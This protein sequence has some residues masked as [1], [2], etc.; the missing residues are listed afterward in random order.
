MDAPYPDSKSAACPTGYHNCGQGTY[1]L[2]RSVCEPDVK[3]PN[4]Q[5]PQPCPLNWLGSTATISLFGVTDASTLTATSTGFTPEPTQVTNN[6]T[7][8]TVIYGQVG[9]TNMIKKQ[10]PIVELQ[11]DFKQSGDQGPCYT[12]NS[13]QNSYAS[14]FSLSSTTGG[15]TPSYPSKCSESDPRWMPFDINIESSYLQENFKTYTA[16]AN[17]PSTGYNPDYFSTPNNPCDP[18]A[19]TG[20]KQCVGIY[21]YQGSVA[22]PTISECNGDKLCLTANYQ[23]KC[24]FLMASAKASTNTMGLYMRSQIYWSET[25]PY[26]YDQVKQSNGPLQKAI[27]SQLALLIINII[28]NIIV[29]LLALWAFKEILCDRDKSDEDIIAIEKGWGP[30]ISSCSTW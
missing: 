16:C 24:G 21:T 27:S 13:D 22:R 17:I 7:V 10:L 26:K 5:D 23:S 14:S 4:P 30:K 8:P 19:T 29:I 28:M 6:F 11:M 2:T 3:L 25:C 12:F 1:D 15:M 20:Y 18:L 9:M